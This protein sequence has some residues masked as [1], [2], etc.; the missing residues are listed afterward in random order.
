MAGLVE[1]AI[2]I[3][4]GSERKLSVIANN[5]TNISTAGFKRQLSF[6]GASGLGDGGLAASS[7]QLRSDFTQGRLSETGN[8]LDLA[9]SGT[10]FFRLRDG[11]SM[12]YS[13][14]GQFRLDADGTLVNAQGH[15][16]QQADG[17]DLVLDDAD[18]QVLADGTVLA[19]GR[20]V[21]RIALY[22]PSEGT[23][24]EASGGTRFAI[25]EDSVEETSESE[26]RQGMVEASNVSLGDE[27]VGMMAAIRQAESGARLVQV[28]DELLGRAL[29]TFGQSGR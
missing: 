3:M 21:A 6:T 24:A 28:Y 5:V 8:P 25:A 20:P 27:M 13:R 11:N 9:I 15:V 19:A 4:S 10:G 29:T 12:V 14:H 1:S 16:L 2:A 22:A 26:L 23:V 7:L 18:V 17:G